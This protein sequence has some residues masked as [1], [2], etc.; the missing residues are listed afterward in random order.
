MPTLRI[1]NVQY[2][3][4]QS[5]N[6]QK[7]W[8]EYKFDELT[9]WINIQRR[10]QPILQLPPVSGYLCVSLVRFRYSLGVV[11]GHSSVFTL[12][13]TAGFFQNDETTASQHGKYHYYPYFGRGTKI[14]TVGE[15]H[16]KCNWFPKSV[17]AKCILRIFGK[18]ACHCT[19]KKNV[20]YRKSQI[21]VYGKGE[22]KGTLQR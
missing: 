2:F 5:E 19:Y 15:W 7:M 11:L 9:W 17:G 8:Y 6:E 14:F 12:P 22:Y 20:W 3:P 13:C 16:H 4:M 18:Q 1:H 21:Y 10:V